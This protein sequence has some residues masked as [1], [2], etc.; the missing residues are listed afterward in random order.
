RGAARPHLGGRDHRRPGGRRRDERP[1]RR[2]PQARSLHG[3]P[4]RGLARGLAPDQV[5]V[6][7]SR[8]HEPR[9]AGAVRRRAMKVSMHNWMRPEPIE[10]TIA[11]LSRLGYE[12]IEISGEPQA[13]DARQVRAL[14][15]EH[16]IECWGAVTLMMGGRDLLHEDP[17]MRLASVRYVK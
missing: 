15:D 7:S 2:R 6:R 16:G 12:G 4:A 10:H 13:Y 5:R 8:H 9:Q 17:Y 14:L 11:R 3:R 1:P